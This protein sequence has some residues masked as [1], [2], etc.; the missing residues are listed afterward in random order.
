MVRQVPWDEMPRYY[1][2]NKEKLLPVEQKPKSEE[3]EVKSKENDLKEIGRRTSFGVLSGAILGCA[4]ATVQVTNSAKDMAADRRVTTA[5]I[6]RSAGLCAGFFGGYHGL[7]SALEFSSQM[8]TSNCMLTAAF[9]SLAPLLAVPKLRS[10]FPYGVVLL[11]I[12]AAYE[13]KP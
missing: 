8:P 2:P 10:T 9:F 11:A 13:Y 3:V 7:R 5:K 4:A 12:D 1:S 6:L